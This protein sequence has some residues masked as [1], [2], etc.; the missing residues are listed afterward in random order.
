VILYV[1][2]SP[3]RQQFRNLGP[4]TAHVLVQLYYLRVLLFRPFV[5]FNVGV[6]MIVP[7]IMI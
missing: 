1:I 5:L 2:V 6:E 7:P 4:L 3:P